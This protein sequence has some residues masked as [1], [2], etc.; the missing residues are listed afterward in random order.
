MV[1]FWNFGAMQESGGSHTEIRRKCGLHNNLEIVLHIKEQPAS[2]KN[3]VK[4][5]HMIFDL[6][7]FMTSEFWP[8]HVYYKHKTSFPMIIINHYFDAVYVT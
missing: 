2:R 3:R 8:L 6:G 7:Q 1:P 4:P 5:I